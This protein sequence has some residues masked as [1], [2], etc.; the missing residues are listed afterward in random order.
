MKC[1]EKYVINENTVCI[2]GKIDDYNRPYSMIIECD[3]DFSV[4]MSPVDIVDTS[5][6]FYC[7]SLKGAS[8]G[9][10]SVLGNISMLPLVIYAP[11]DLYMFP[12]FS[13]HR[14]DCI[15][16]SVKHIRNFE[17]MEKKNTIVYTKTGQTITL[18][19]KKDRFERK[20]QRASQLRYV[21]EERMRKAATKSKIWS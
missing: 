10:R 5:L 8:E 11:L 20:W 19:M 16:F 7:S 3:Q 13:P 9:A 4:R 2:K 15:W 1:R 12:S 6:R 17:A 14:L 21:T 18:A